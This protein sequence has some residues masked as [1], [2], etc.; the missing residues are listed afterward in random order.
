MG[1]FINADA[2]ASTG[3]GILGCNMFAY[4]RNNSVNRIDIPG[5]ADTSF[6]ERCDDDTEVVPPSAAGAGGASGSTGNGG[7]SGVSGAAGAQSTGQGFSS[8]SSLKSF[9]GSAGIGKH[10]HHIVEQ[11]Q[12][13]KSG[14]SS[15]QVN[16]TSNVIAVDAS[17]HS[18]ITG[19]YNSTK[20]EFTGGLS[21]RNWLAGQPFQFQFDFGMGVL[22]DLGVIK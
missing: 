9:L 20:F 8:F 14:F 11:S 13:Q 5:Y 15:E 21:V 18:Q 7:T 17:V 22:R 19:Y 10:W 3:Q 1:R 16:N 6:E 12:M 4:C 2:F